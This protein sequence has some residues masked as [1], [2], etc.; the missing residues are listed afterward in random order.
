MA[1]KMIQCG[2]CQ[3]EIAISAKNCPKCG[4]K[5]KKYGLMKKRIIGGILLLIGII[6]MISDAQR[7]AERSIGTP[8]PSEDISK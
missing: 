8:S 2:A 7:G 5:N 3:A 1:E 4:G 6:W